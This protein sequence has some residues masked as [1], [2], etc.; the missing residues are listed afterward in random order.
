MSKKIFTK[1]PI[2]TFTLFYFLAVA[3]RFRVAVEYRFIKSIICKVINLKKNIYRNFVL[4][5]YKAINN[6]EQLSI[7]DTSINR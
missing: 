6:L 1:T 7:N 2:M 5:Y 4:S 3:T